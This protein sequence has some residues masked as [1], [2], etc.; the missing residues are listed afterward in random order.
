M[1]AMSYDAKFLAAVQIIDGTH[2]R[3]IPSL[4]DGESFAEAWEALGQDDRDRLWTLACS[5]KLESSGEMPES[6]R[7]GLQEADIIQRYS[8]SV[9]RT[10]EL[11]AVANVRLPSA[12]QLTIRGEWQAHPG[13]L[14]EETL[15]LSIAGE[16]LDSL[17]TIDGP[18]AAHLHRAVTATAEKIFRANGDIQ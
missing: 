1:I 7:V 14:R 6:L 8:F 2:P 9:V 12:G 18:T 3:P 17:W 4:E 13:G 5:G 16:P 11:Q 15:E 10:G